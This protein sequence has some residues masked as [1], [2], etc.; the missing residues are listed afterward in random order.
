MKGGYLISLVLILCCFTVE[1]LNFTITHFK[2]D[3]DGARTVIFNVDCGES[4]K[5][6]ITAAY[7]G[8]IQSVASVIYPIIHVRFA[9]LTVYVVDIFVISRIFKCQFDSSCFHNHSSRIGLSHLSLLFAR[10]TQPF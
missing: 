5:A 3:Y 7:S 9:V 8:S 2:R 4:M 10:C 1:F 6:I